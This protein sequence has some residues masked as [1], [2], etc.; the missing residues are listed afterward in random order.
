[1][2]PFDYRV[3]QMRERALLVCMALNIPAHEI[4]PDGVER[5]RFIAMDLVML[6]AKLRVLGVAHAE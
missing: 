3:D 1:M 2:S 6:S 5:W 4:S